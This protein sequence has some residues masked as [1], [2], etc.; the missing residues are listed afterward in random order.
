M[1]THRIIERAVRSRLAGVLVGVALG[2]PA[3]VTLDQARAASGSPTAA[4]TGVTWRAT[5]MPPEGT[6]PRSADSAAGMPLI[7]G[8]AT[9]AGAGAKQTRATIYVT[10][11]P[12]KSVLPWHVHRGQCGKDEGIVGPANVYTPI[13]VGGNG[14]GQIAQTLPFA[15]PTSGNYMVNV[16][17]SPDE[18]KTI[19]AC[20][21]LQKE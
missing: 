3:L 7:G 4:D 10:H 11:A 20:G 17:K 19:L 18:L 1:N 13:H 6:S 14:E 9:L 16:H 15:T 21:N 12:P 2:L 5:L 8:A